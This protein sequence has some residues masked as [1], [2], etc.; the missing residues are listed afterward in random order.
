MDEFSI[1]IL[2]ITFGLVNYSLLAK[3]YVLPALNKLPRA[4]ALVPLI[5]PHCFRY[6]GLVFIVRGVVSPK[7]SAVFA[8]PAAYGDLLAAVLALIA[9]VSLRRG[10]S[11]SMPLV[12]LFNVVGTLDLLFAVYR[13]L[14]FTF[15]HQLVA[16]YFIPVVIV[17][18][19]LVSHFIIFKCLLCG[20]KTAT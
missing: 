1:L 6:I 15:P 11:L 12:W 5:F 2:S 8:Y 13:G 18:A 16:A 19:L 14:R 4:Q 9:V 3:W 7:L 17:P 20:E 10:W